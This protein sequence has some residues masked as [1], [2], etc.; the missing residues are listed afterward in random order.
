MANYQAE[1]LMQ[2]YF[3]STLHACR[4]NLFVGGYLEDLCLSVCLFPERQMQ[5]SRGPV[6]P[7]LASPAIVIGFDSK[8]A[9]DHQQQQQQQSRY[10]IIM[11]TV[12]TPTTTSPLRQQSPGNHNDVIVAEPKRSTC[13]SNSFTSTGYSEG[14]RDEV[15]GK[16][17][18]GFMPNS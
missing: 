10:P 3:Q 8:D 9:A 1:M 7:C 16:Y 5:L 12:A 17:V 14:Y 2:K 13:R 11:R 4:Y 15:S 6:V 18:V